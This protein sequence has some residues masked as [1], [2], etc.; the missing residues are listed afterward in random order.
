MKSARISRLLWCA[1]AVALV[2]NV[3]LA[4]HR[5]NDSY[6]QTNLDRVAFPMGGIG[7]GMICLE[8]TG[9]LSHF[10]LRNRPDILSER[11][12]FSAICVKGD[13]NIAR[14]LEGQVPKWKVFAIHPGTGQ[15]G[16]PGNGLGETTYGLPRFRKASFHSRFPFGVVSLQ[17]AKVPLKVEIIGWSPFAPPDADA[18]SLPMV[19][20]EY[21]FSNTSKEKIEAV[22]SFNAANFMSVRGH[23]PRIDRIAG[24]FVLSQPLGGTL[25]KQDEGYLAAFVDEPDAKVNAAWFRGGWFDP[26]T[27]VWKDIEQGN[28]YDR[29]FPTEGGASSGATLFVPFELAPGETRTIALKLCWYVPNSDVRQGDETSPEG[30]RQMYQPWYAGR[31]DSIGA[32]VAEWR[33]SYDRL[34]AESKKFSECFYDTTLPAEVVEAVAANLTILK[35]PT[36]LR[37]TDGRFW[38]FEGCHDGAG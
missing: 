24:G 22:F 21:R 16:G 26:L 31:F 37:Q 14:V 1:A 35:S 13:E 19:G 9:M 20:V 18:S 36:V 25:K 27:I 4:E 29:D 3:A 12:V 6:T 30:E 2:G 33:R 38:A 5:Y 28:C 15:Y 11:K 10:S 7:A 17:D 8:G 23:E 32:V 34:R